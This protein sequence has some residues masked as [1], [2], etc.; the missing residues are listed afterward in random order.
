MTTIGAW[1]GWSWFQAAMLS[2]QLPRSWLRFLLYS[3]PGS[4][5]YS[6]LLSLASGLSWL[7]RHRLLTLSAYTS[8]SSSEAPES[9]ACAQYMYLSFS[10]GLCVPIAVVSENF[11]DVART[12]P[13]IA[14]NIAAAP[15]NAATRP[16][17]RMGQFPF[18]VAE[19]AAA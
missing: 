14:T 9:S 15:T 12:L 19:L 3:S 7:T 2:R 8:S 17:T 18:V 5:A 4:S 13:G 1:S 16:R 10:Y 11:G 6:Q